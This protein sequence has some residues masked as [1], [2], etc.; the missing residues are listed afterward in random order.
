[1]IN[2]EGLCGWGVGQTRDFE[3]QNFEGVRLLWGE[4]QVR[5]TDRQDLNFQNRDSV[6]QTENNW[7][8]FSGE[9]LYVI[10]LDEMQS[11]AVLSLVVFFFVRSSKYR[12]VGVRCGWESYRVGRLVSGLVVPPSPTPPT[13]ISC[14]ATRVSA[15]TW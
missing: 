10:A 5:Q 4:N 3:N 8:Y 2:G 9:M 1:M 14:E 15:K 7:S 6:L 13:N 11:S 12:L